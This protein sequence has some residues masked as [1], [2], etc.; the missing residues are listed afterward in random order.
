ISTIIFSWILVIPLG[1]ICGYFKNKFIDRVILFFS[2]LGI[3]SPS[4]F[5]AFI[6]LYFAYI[7]R[8]FPL[9]GR[10]SVY[11]DQLPYFLKF[12]DLVKHMILPVLVLS[13]A[14]VSSLIK[15]FRSNI[16]ETLGS[17]YI[18][19]LKATGIS[20]RRIFYVHILRAAINPMITIFGYEISSLL[21]GAALVEI[22]FG[23]PGL[24]QVM[25]EAVQKQD[26]Y[27]V[28]GSVL[29]SGILLILGNFIADI[30]LAFFDP[31]I[32][33]K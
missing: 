32:R 12:L 18:L 17:N 19:A 15:I 13:I 8:L 16:L 2:Y 9:G 3:S 11:F 22:I 5:L 23:W 30:L 21:S 1:I 10:T 26:L 25:L 29:I 33:L 14:R 24:G 28:M 6:F 31:R 27:L 20:K 4:F 7:T